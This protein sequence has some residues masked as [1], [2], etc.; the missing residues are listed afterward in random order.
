MTARARSEPGIAAGAA[1][2]LVS[3]LGMA[4]CAA[5]AIR[6]GR[7]AGDARQALGFDFAGVAR[8]PAQ[9]A[10]LALTNAR[11]AAGTLVCA[12]IAPRTGRR[13]RGA[14]LALLTAVLVTSAAAVGVTIGAYATRAIRALAPHL[15]VEF[16]GLSLAGG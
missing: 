6:L 2:C 1:R 13:L 5:T 4:A 10:Q 3:A 15:V 14:T 9:V 16:A 12:L 8:S 7:L 11:I